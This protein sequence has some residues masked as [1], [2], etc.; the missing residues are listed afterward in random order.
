[1]LAVGRDE[2]RTKGMKQRSRIKRNS[3][4]YKVGLSEEG[5]AGFHETTHHTLKYKH[6]GIPWLFKSKKSLASHVRLEILKG[7]LTPFGRSFNFDY[8]PGSGGERDFHFR[9][10]NAAQRRT[11]QL[12]NK[13]FYCSFTHFR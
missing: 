10:M 12:G 5:R 1:M 11:V 6:R 13:G 7:K 8:E 2:E 3:R 9:H 4:L